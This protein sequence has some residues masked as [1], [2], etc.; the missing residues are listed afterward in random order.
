MPVSDDELRGVLERFAKL[1]PRPEP[2]GTRLSDLRRG[3]R[4]PPR[5]TELALIERQG[6]VTWEFGRAFSSRPI[7]TAGRRAGRRTAI[8]EKVLF[9]DRTE[10]LGVNQIGQYLMDF[11]LN[12]NQDIDRQ[13]GWT[14]RQWHN[15]TEK[16]LKPVELSKEGPLLVIVHGTGSTCGHIIDELRA[17]P[18][19]SGKRLLADASRHY[20]AV[21]A[22][23]HPTLAFSPM[24][25]AL[26]LSKA[27]EPYGDRAVDIVCHSRGGLVSSWWMHLVDQRQRK[28]RCVFV[29]SPL[30]GT[31]L[32][33]PARLRES[34][35]LLATYGRLLG[36][37][38][39]ATGFLSLPFA[40]L[41]VV[42]AAADF[43]SRIRCSTPGLQ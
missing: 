12:L 29:G 18:N 4:R 33:N 10:P 9:V 31:S 41:K 19:D 36:D 1:T 43:T 8:G 42:S 32:A 13:R 22:F 20:A 25:N 34:L 28:R 24:I 23:D 27:L 15:A 6:F 39:Q 17:A 14:L 3:R 38:G 5:M 2:E 26:D 40:I 21:L 30:Q 7:P 16:L 11:D 37:V 35:N